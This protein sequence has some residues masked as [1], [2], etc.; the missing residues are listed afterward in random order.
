MRK[1]T[2]KMVRAMKAQITEITAAVRILCLE[3]QCC[4]S[5]PSF[6]SW[7]LTGCET[8]PKIVCFGDG[9]KG[10]SSSPDIFFGFLLTFQKFSI[11]FREFKHPYFCLFVCLDSANCPLSKSLR[12]LS[13]LPQ[14]P[15]FKL[16]PL[17]FLFSQTKPIK[18][19]Y[20]YSLCAGRCVG[21]SC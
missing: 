10:S 4:P 6:S 1:R 18:A 15:S 7:P 21:L 12:F 16:P 8:E 2:R 17:S 14:R 13:Y 20:F 9:S 19:K 3:T 5:S 11:T